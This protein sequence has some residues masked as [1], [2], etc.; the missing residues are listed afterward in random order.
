MEEADYATYGKMMNGMGNGM[1]QPNRNTTRAEF[2]TVLYRLEGQ[3]AVSGG[4]VPFMDVK[5]GSW[6]EKAVAWA[7]E[8]DIVKGVSASAFAP[9]ANITREQ[10]VTMLQRYA[11]RV[12]D[13]TG[14]AS[15]LNPFADKGQVSSW[16]KDAMQWA[17]EA[18]VIKG[19][20]ATKLDPKGLVTRA[21]I[22][23]L[24]MQFCES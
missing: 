18:G 24:M 13:C 5:A 17:V 8:N 14:S 1:F 11:S 4:F 10:M 20:S 2:V 21:Q 19:V 12:G 16:A 7:Y 15:A 3:P 6:Y 23:A 9:N 22:A